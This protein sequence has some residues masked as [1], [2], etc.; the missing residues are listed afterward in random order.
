MKSVT[1]GDDFL[2][3]SRYLE[4]NQGKIEEFQLGKMNFCIIKFY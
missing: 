4:N 2:G 3:I 1:F